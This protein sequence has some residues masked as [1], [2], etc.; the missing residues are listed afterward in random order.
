MARRELGPADFIS[1]NAN[2]PC[3]NPN[4]HSHGAPHVGCK[5][6]SQS[7]GP[8]ARTPDQLG[9]GQVGPEHFSENFAHGGNVHYCSLG[10]K[11]LPG[12]EYYADGGKVEQNH[13]FNSNPELAVDHAVAN[14]GL[15]HLLTKTGHS[16][17]EDPHRPAQEF[18]EHSKKGHDKL[19]S[20]VHGIFESKNDKH[21]IDHE[22]LDHL[23]NHLESLRQN[24]DRIMDMGGNLSESLPLHAGMAAAKAANAAQYLHSIKPMGNQLS[25]LDRISKPSKMEENDYDRQVQI[26]Q[27]PLSIIKHIK[28]GAVRPADLQTLQTLYPQL[29]K[30]IQDKSFEKVAELKGNGTK[31]PLRQKAGLSSLLG[32][33]ESTQTPQAMQAII[34][35]AG[36]NAQPQEQQKPQKSKG[37]A[38]AATQKTIEKTDR[39]Y[40][41]PTDQLIMNRK[42]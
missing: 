14:H 8:V 18:I 22:S 4:C 33:L 16:R 23:K 3:L 41:T 35:S 11:H 38:T 40:E 17:S 28:M 32:P 10:L 15:L 26:A 20:H 42:S 21:E 30:S 19:Q 34:A 39:L 27:N 37:G 31:I 12:C 7:G 5:C 6:Y 36:G 13:Q 25:P 2:L 29:S 9:M 24:P 1:V